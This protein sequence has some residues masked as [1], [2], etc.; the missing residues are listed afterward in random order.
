MRAFLTGVALSVLVAGVAVAQDMGPPPGGPDGPGGP[1]MAPMMQPLKRTDVAGIVAKHFAM[2]DLNH[3]NVIDAADRVAMVAKRRADRE[4][5]M[6][7]HRDRMFAELD[8]NKDGS[9]SRAEF[10]AAPP[11]PPPPGERGPDGGPGGPGGPDGMRGP[12]GPGPD[13]MRGPRGG[14]DG[15]GGMDRPMRGPGM[16][17]IS[18][19]LL[20]QADLNH[21][22]KV[23]LAEAQKAALGWFDKA[24]VNHDGTIDRDEMI[25]AMQGHMR[26]RGGH[27]G[28]EGK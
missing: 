20:E 15:P 21:D 7:M 27:G 10:D 25:V 17:M 19:R 22:G 6:K 14:P 8:A 26:G 28:P 16:G 23:T 3:D 4:A 13:G 1:R 18:G 11:P 9:I 2:M 24:D 5:R 12:G